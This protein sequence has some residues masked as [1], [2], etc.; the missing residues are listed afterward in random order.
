MSL[1][2][3]RARSNSSYDECIVHLLSAFFCVTGRTREDK[4]L[5]SE[6]EAVLTSLTTA[7]AITPPSNVIQFRRD[8]QR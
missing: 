3:N 1:K 6:I 8:N 4:R 5:R 2:R 7:Q